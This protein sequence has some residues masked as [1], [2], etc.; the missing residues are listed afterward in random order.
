MLV[1][2]DCVLMS[3]DKMH[4]PGAILDVPSVSEQ[5][6]LLISDFALKRNLDIVTASFV[7]KPEDVEDVRRILDDKEQGKRVLIYAKV[8]SLEGLRNFEEILQVADGIMIDRQSLGME[9]TPDKS[10]IAQKWMV[11]KANVACKP[12]ITYMQVLDS[13]TIIPDPN[14]PD[15]GEPL[16]EDELKPKRYEA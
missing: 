16:T 14:N 13:M 12:V 4:L 2:N 11:M 6:S 7:R 5:D 8:Q 3:D 15:T 10:I 1:K 9:L